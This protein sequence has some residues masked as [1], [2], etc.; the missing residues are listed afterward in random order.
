M[1]ITSVNVRPSRRNAPVGWV[2][3]ELTKTDEPIPGL[4]GRFKS[5]RCI[6]PRAKNGQRGIRFSSPR[7]A[8]DFYEEHK[9]EDA[10]T[11]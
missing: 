5:K 4:W 10:D 11:T 1:A 8:M 7:L 9:D 3:E 2:L 6:W